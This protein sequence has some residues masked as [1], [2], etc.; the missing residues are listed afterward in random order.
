MQSNSPTTAIRVVS[1]VK[2]VG[3]AETE[4]CL[5]RA[6]VTNTELKARMVEFLAVTATFCP[7]LL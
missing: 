7:L 4:R 1:V 3:L 2:E 6:Q 5:N